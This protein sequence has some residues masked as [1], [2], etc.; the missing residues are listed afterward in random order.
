MKRARENDEAGGFSNADGSQTLAAVPTAS[1]ATRTAA[2]GGTNFTAPSAALTIDTAAYASQLDAKLGKLKAL[3]SDLPMPEVEVRTSEPEHYRL[4][5]EF[6]VWGAREGERLHYIMFSTAAANSAS[7]AATSEGAAGGGDEEGTLPPQGDPIGPDDG[8]DKD[9]AA[10]GDVG[11]TAVTP[12]V[13][14]TGSTGA[15]TTEGVASAAGSAGAGRAASGPPGKGRKGRKQQK[16]PRAPRVEITSFPVGSRLINE[17]MPV[18]LEACNK[19]PVLKMGLF[20]ASAC[21]RG[22]DRLGVRG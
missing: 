10:E 3:F 11:V 14:P 2:A 17:L 22:R 18:V 7:A 13:T 16:K 4:R 15:P 5:A 20:Q 8:E 1:H 6:N 9:A 21:R 12:A 19:N